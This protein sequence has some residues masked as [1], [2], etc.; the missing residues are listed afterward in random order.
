M[1]ALAV[2]GYQGTAGACSRASGDVLVKEDVRVNEVV[3]ET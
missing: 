3:L 2:T 1:R